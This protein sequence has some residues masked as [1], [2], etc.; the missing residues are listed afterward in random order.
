MMKTIIYYFT[1]RG[2]LAAVCPVKN[3][4]LVGKKPVWN[5]TVNYVV[6]PDNFCPVEAIHYCPKNGKT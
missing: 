1:N 6:V 2:L 3:I 5:T 4:D